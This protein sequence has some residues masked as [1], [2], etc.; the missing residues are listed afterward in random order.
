MKELLDTLQ[1]LQSQPPL[2]ER[3]ELKFWDDP[4]ISKCMLE[5]HL[6]AD[7]DLASRR[8]ETIDRTVKHLFSSGTLQ[9]GM[10]VLDLGCG[11]GLYAERFSK[12]GCLVTGLDLSEGSLTYAREH[13]KEQ[14]LDI[15]Y[16]CMNFLE[17]DYSDTFD[18]ALQIYGEVNTFSDEA[19][20]KLFSLIH[21]ALKKKGKFIFD[22]ST[23]VH[24][25]K[26]GCKDGW[27]VSDGGFFSPRR[28][29]VLERGFDYPE[30]SVW[31]DQYI[32]AEQQECKVYR[33]WF[34]DF[35]LDGITEVLRKAGFSVKSVWNELTGVPYQEG[36]EWIAIAAEVEK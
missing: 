27:Y 21:K 24:R 25:M 8:P 10:R 34:H 17:M 32:V 14:G 13:A 35:T 9:P 6:N 15:E 18:A 1:R 5:T 28:H 12:A 4:H 3:G 11:P 36:G 23:R 16:R 20:Q 29:M 19:R 31:L 2:F 7:T 26:Y 30:Q 22:I 33:N